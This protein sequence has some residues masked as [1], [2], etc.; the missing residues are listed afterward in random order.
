MSATMIAATVSQNFREE[1]SSTS[2]ARI[3]ISRVPACRGTS[4]GGRKDTP[5]AHHG[6]ERATASVPGTC[7]KRARNRARQA[8]ARDRKLKSGWQLYA[9]AAGWRSAVAVDVWR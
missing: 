9:R 5:D 7:Q 1:R 3:V 8:Q 4:R 6:R 2:F